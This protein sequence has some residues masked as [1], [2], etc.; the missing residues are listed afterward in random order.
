[1]NGSVSLSGRHRLSSPV[2]WAPWQA[3]KRTTVLPLLIARTVS[4]IAR[5]NSAVNTCAQRSHTWHHDE[6]EDQATVAPGNDDAGRGFL[7]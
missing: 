1:M 5:S 2:R 6:S 3:H 7:G 4:I